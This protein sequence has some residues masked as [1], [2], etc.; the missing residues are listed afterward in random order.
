MAVP[1]PRVD[2]TPGYFDAMPLWPRSLLWRTFALLALLG[3]ATTVGW[4]LIFRT[5][6]QTPRA[7]QIAQNIVSVVNLTRAALVTAQSD[8]R[9]ELLM[10]L[11]E[12]EGIEIYT[13]EADDQIIEPPETPLV[14]LIIADLREQLGAQTRLGFERNGLPGLWVSF[15]IDGDDY[16]VRIPRE[17]LERAV[18]LQWLGWGALALVLS[19]IAAYLAVSHVNRPLK[20]LAKAASDIGHGRTP[21]PVAETGAMEILAVA[22]AFNQMSRDLQR[23]DQ[24]RAIILA[25]ISHDLRTPLARLRLGTEMS[26]ADDLL[27]EGMRTDIEEMDRTIGQFLDFARVSSDSGDSGE[28]LQPTCLSSLAEELVEQYGKLGHK[29]DAHIEVTPELGLRRQ[30]MRRVLA[31]LIDNALRHAGSD[32]EIRTCR[33]NG[34]VVA[35]VLDRGP[36]IPA[37][38]AERMKQ[39]FTQL[40]Q[41]RSGALGS[42][43]G[44][45]IVDRV[46]RSHG[47]SFDLLPRP[48]G[49]LIARIRLPETPR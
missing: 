26:P 2:A 48:G 32:I 16:W 5:Y 46:A 36:G 13:G 30:A 11:N 6:E 29:I 39:P 41:A 22:R 18:A 9:R 10:D 15:A 42:G 20:A 47:G 33:E 1:P 28:A 35:E 23:L 14:N 17:R 45:A 40:E 21:A 44:L 12:R 25:G 3:V 37:D 43:L 7:S 38:Q 31:N 24:D 49:G 34:S 4:F 8:L 27:K 19:L